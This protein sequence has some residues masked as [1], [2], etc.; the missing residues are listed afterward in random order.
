MNFF[1]FF[2]N[3]TI[4]SNS[5]FSSSTPATSSNVTLVLSV[6][7]TSLALLFPNVMVLAPPWLLPFIIKNQNIKNII[8]KP[9][10]VKKLSTVTNID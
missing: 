3:S 8:N 6:A 4:S 5:S 2:K 10:G 1:G 7:F 9:N